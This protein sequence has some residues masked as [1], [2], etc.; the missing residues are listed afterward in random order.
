VIVG[1]KFKLITNFLYYFYRA[2]VGARA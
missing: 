2:I 1:G